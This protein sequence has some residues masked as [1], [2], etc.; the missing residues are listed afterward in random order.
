MAKESQVLN[1]EITSVI[2]WPR[3]HLFHNPISKLIILRDVFTN[4][5][6]NPL[7]CD[8][9]NANGNLKTDNTKSAH[10]SEN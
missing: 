1:M 8:L 6:E 2:A 4:G 9:V 3:T 7:F 5:E 10:D